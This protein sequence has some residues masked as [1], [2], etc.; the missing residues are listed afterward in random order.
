[1]VSAHEET[2]LL[3]DFFSEV[4]TLNAGFEE[5]ND[6]R[7]YPNKKTKMIDISNKDNT[8]HRT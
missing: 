4:F 8:I 6:G 2:K 7:E 5:L 3:L 1:M